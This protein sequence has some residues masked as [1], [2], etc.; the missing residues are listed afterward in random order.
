[1]AFAWSRVGNN[2][3]G[4]EEPETKKYIQFDNILDQKYTLSLKSLPLGCS[5]AFSFLL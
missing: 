3:K 4:W 5:I 2:D 1:M